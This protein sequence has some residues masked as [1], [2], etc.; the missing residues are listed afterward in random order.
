MLQLTVN[1]CVGLSDH[2]APSS[3]DVLVHKV[4]NGR[5]H[6]MFPTTLPVVRVKMGAGNLSRLDPTLC[7]PEIAPLSTGCL[8]I[9]EAL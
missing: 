9:S 3:D 2:F 5:R 1:G 7:Y 8:A 6:L 4:P